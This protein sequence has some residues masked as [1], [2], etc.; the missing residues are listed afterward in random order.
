M[1]KFT[2][3]LVWHN[4][5]TDPPKESYNSWLTFTD[6][7]HVDHCTYHKRY[8]FPISEDMLHKFWWTD[9]SRAVGESVEFKEL[10]K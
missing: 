2:M 10:Q 3:G 7:Y 4:C 1:D 8:G 9:L 6:G 5:K